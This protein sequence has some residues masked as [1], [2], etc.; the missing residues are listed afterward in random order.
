MFVFP[1]Y[2]P[3]YRQTSC[4]RYGGRAGLQKI[5]EHRRDGWITHPASEQSMPFFFTVFSYSVTQ[6]SGDKV[7]IGVYV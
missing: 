5:S 4:R 7:Y 2:G 1:P 6:D 3:L